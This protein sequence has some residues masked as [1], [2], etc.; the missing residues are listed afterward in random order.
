V[1]VPGKP[2]QPRVTFGGYSQES[3]LEW[4][5][6]THKHQTRLEMLARDKH[7]SLLRK[8]VNYGQKSFKHWTQDSLVK[9][10]D[11]V[12]QDGYSDEED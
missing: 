6:R 10:Y 12:T 2:F 11:E 4:N 8:F 3:T 5:G 7:S 9:D 1:F